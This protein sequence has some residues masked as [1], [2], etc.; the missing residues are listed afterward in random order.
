M[1]KTHGASGKKCSLPINEELFKPPDPEL[2][3]VLDDLEKQKYQ[4]LVGSLLFVSRMSRPDIAI[5]VN[6]LGRRASNPSQRNW[7]AA[8][9][10]L[11]YLS[12]T[13]SEGIILH[14]PQTLN[15]A[16]YADASYGGEQ[17]RSQSGVLLTLA[18]QPVGWYSRRQDIVSQ[19]GT[20]AEYIADCEGGKDQACARQLLEELGMRM[21]IPLL[22]TD[23]EGAYNHSK[24]VKFSRWS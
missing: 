21:E 14:K 9:N 8:M 5:Q 3:K 1:T 7:K 11:L 19:S 15:L 16:V 23:S 6:L 20:E 17:S 12:M 10:T 24:T 13:S 4:A 22:V 18:N 2:N